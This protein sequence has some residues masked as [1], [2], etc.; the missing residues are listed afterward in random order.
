L[1]FRHAAKLE[2]ACLNRLGAPELFAPDERA[3]PVGAV[4][5]DRVFAADVEVALPVPVAAVPVLFED[6]PVPLDAPPQAAKVRAAHRSRSVLAGRQRAGEVRANGTVS[7]GALT[8]S[9]CLPR[10]GVAIGLAR[11]FISSSSS[12]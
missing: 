8:L 11:H 1:L 12:R 2:R 10:L 7:E 9:P 5:V 3:A 4:E 6:V